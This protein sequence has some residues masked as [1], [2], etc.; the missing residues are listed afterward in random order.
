[1]QNCRVLS[2]PSVRGNN[3]LVVKTLVGKT[4]VV[5]TRVVK[6]R[7]VKTL[8]VKTLCRIVA[9]SQFRR[10]EVIH[11]GLFCGVSR[12]LFAVLVGLFCGVGRSLLR[13]W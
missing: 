7:V 3:T 4:R 6:T 5:K 11:I 2:V 12:S 1:M 8:V 10:S 13:C 9:F